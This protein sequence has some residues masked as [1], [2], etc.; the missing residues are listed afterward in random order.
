M[1][2]KPSSLVLCVL[3]LF[4]ERDGIIVCSERSERP[5]DVG[6]GVS[7]VRENIQTARGVVAIMAVGS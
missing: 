3:K 6:H 7:Y 4:V 5:S 1:F 2:S